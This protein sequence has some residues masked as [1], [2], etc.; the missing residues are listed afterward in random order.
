L[1]D[2]RSDTVQRRRAVSKNGIDVSDPGSSNGPSL[3]TGVSST[4]LPFVGISIM[5]LHCIM[6][7]E[8]FEWFI[9]CQRASWSE[10]VEEC[11][12]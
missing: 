11:V 2:V 1:G 4:A 10:Q 7:V 6:R 12:A 5:L 9:L 3:G 8:H